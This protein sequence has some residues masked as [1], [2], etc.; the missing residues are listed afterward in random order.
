MVAAQPQPICQSPSRI[1]PGSGLR[2][3]QPKAS[4][5]LS[6]QGISERELIRQTFDRFVHGVVAPTQFDRIHLQFIRS[7]SIALSIA[8]IYGVSGGE[9][10]NPGVLRSALHDIEH[11]GVD[12]PAGVKP[13]R[14]VVPETL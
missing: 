4:A 2:A 6:K 1:D 11:L 9:R 13:G 8:K 12:D 5:A 3:D 10:M 7:S 14:C